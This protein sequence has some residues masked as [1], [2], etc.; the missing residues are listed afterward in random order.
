MS[1]VSQRRTTKHS[2]ALPNCA[3]LDQ[4]GPLRGPLA[5]RQR[6]AL[7]LGRPARRTPGHTVQA[8][9]STV[10][11]SEPSWFRPV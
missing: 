6:R 4:G 5:R 7:P 2:E 11:H 8:P 3:V 9:L 1:H 10:A